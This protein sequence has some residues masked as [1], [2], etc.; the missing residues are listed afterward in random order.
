M[1][2]LSTLSVK[3]RSST[4]DFRTPLLVPPLRCCLEQTCFRTNPTTSSVR[5]HQIQQ[6][7]PIVRLAQNGLP[8]HCTGF[9]ADVLSQHGCHGGRLVKINL[10]QFSTNSNRTL[11]D[12]N[13]PQRKTNMK[14]WASIA[15]VAPHTAA[16]RLFC[17]PFRG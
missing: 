17:L 7:L 6:V 1:N 8:S 3:R 2:S 12:D 13:V 10:R 11:W 16:P 15:C 9:T 4:V 14:I 5:H